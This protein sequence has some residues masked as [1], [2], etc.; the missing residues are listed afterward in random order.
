MERFPL[1]YEVKWTDHNKLTYEKL[2]NQK[3]GHAD[4]M[5][6]YVLEE[7][8]KGGHIISPRIAITTQE[9][10]YVWSRLLG[11]YSR[12]QCSKSFVKNF[13]SKI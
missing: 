7:F 12:L 10:I 2:L 11:I 6:T 1:E 4:P 9:L 5:L 3:F 8:A 13:Y